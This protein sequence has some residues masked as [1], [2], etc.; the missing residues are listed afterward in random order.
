MFTFPCPTCEAKL[1]VKDEKLIGRILACP[2]CSSMVLVQSPDEAPTPPHKEPTRPPIHKRFPDVLTHETASGVIG[3][4]PDENRRPDLFLEI[5]APEADVSEKEI[6]T[7]MVLIGILIGLSMLLLVALG[8]LMLFRKPDRPQPP[9]P[10]KPVLQVPAEQ[11]PPMP[12]V[13][14]TPAAPT[15]E[16]NESPSNEKPSDTP[17]Q[18]TPTEPETVSDEQSRDTNDS[19]SAF[20]RKMPGFVDASVPNIDIAA[21]LSLPILE[22][23][24]DRQSLIEF[25]R[26]VSNLTGIPMT[27][28][29]DELKPLSLSVKTLVEKQFWDTTVEAILTATLETLGLQWIAT[30]RQILILPKELDDVDLTFDVSDLAENTGDLKPEVLAEMIQKLVCPEA[31]IEA[32]PD[33][34][35]AVV[36]DERGMKSQRRQQDNILR[37]LEQLRVVRQLPQKTDW[38]GETLAPEAFG[39]DQVMEPITL[40]YYRVVPLS[41][42][43]EQLESIT[44]LTILIDHQSLHRALCPFAAIP[45]TVQCNGGTVNDAMELSL[46]SVESVA[47][48][49][50]IIDHQTLEITTAESA[51]QPKKMVVEVHR[52]QLQED[53]TPEDIV[54][55]LRSVVEPETWVVSERPETR[56]GGDI[57]IDHASGCLLVR[58]SQPAQRQIRLYLST[59]DTR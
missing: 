6:K 18:D 10:P 2:K 52:Y 57:V 46:A 7:R 51:R 17:P 50:R 55:S 48:S 33:H 39:W 5:V 43:V 56:Y 28:D 3:H 44:K 20:D 8:F 47:L 45:T 59:L 24:L 54:R 9:E 23:N 1:I 53:E 34:R 16:A 32:L 11:L 36:Q 37:F 15:D 4:V 42:V 38:T 12:Q 40:N 58:Q 30:D 13:E 41:R 35:L 49:Y 14:P 22:L 19:L 29:I 31:S 25:V 27:L 21:K 26:T